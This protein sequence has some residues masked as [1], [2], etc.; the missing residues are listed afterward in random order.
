MI[1]VLDNYDSFTYNLVQLISCLTDVEVFRNDQITVEAVMARQPQGIVISPGPGR[2]ENAGI[3]VD[4]IRAAGAHVPILGI[5][6][7]HQAIALSYG[8][9]IIPAPQLMH[10][11]PDTITHTGQ[12]LFRDVANPL[13]AGR[14]HSLAISLEGALGLKVDARGSDGAIMAISHQNYPVY[15]L[16]FHPESVLTPEGTTFITNFV[17]LALARSVKEGVQV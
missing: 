13:T 11:K 5:C 14:Y 7:G 15:G 1:L 17:E 8:G 2:P 4:L 3:A 12:G 6:L 10:G 9:S 16:Q